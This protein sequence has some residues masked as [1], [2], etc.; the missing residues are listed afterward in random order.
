[1]GAEALAATVGCGRQLITRRQREEALNTKRS[2][3]ERKQSAG[4]RAS[5]RRPDL[6]KNN[7][8]EAFHAAPQPMQNLA[9]HDED[10]GSCRLL[11]GALHLQRVQ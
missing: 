8:R 7:K 3:F 4:S 9:L 1:M 11:E 5:T 10:E 2:R 6:K